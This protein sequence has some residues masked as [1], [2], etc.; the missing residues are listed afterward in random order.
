MGIGND[1]IARRKFKRANR[2]SKHSE[3]LKVSYRIASIIAAKKRRKSGKRSMCQGMCYSLPTIEDPFN[4]RQG[5]L[6]LKRKELKKHAPSKTDRKMSTNRNTIEPK[7]GT[8]DATHANLGCH[9]RK[10]ARFEN[11]E[12]KHTASLTPIG[13][14]GLEN[15]TKLG[16][17]MVQLIGKNAQEKH[18]FEIQGCPS[19][20]LISC[21]NSIEN[22][23]RHDGALITDDDKPLFVNTWG[24]EFWKCYSIGKDV[25][26]TSGACSTTEQI[27]WIVSTAADTIA[28]KEKEG[29]SLTNPFLLF[30]VPSQ[31]K[32]TK[33]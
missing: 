1:A 14:K 20:Y 12:N 7:N 31:E 21:L 28:R 19:K 17:A 22:A 25:V 13:N 30:L 26:N 11:L 18:L 29:L 27:A 16:E 9:E 4:D 23:L 33:V 5:I 2:K 8:L 10:L 6:D 24:V 15:A 3:S 32:A